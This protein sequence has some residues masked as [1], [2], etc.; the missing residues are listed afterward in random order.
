MTSL[1]NQIES[2]VTSILSYANSKL[3]LQE[4]RKNIKSELVNLSTLICLE[5]QDTNSKKESISDLYLKMINQL[6]E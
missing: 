5:F 6:Q 1:K 2:A 3:S 4:K